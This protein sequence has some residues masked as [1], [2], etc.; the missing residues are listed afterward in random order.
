MWTP[1]RILLLLGGFAAFFTAYQ[2]YSAFLGGIDGLTPL[3]EDYWPV[4]DGSQAPMP[5]APLVNLADRKLQQAF[6]EACEELRR[7]TKLEVRN[8]GLVL[9]VDEFTPV[10]GKVR[11]KPFSAAIFGKLHPGEVMPEINT[12][13][14]DVALLQFDRPISNITEMSTRKLMGAELDGDITI[15]NNRRTPQRDD[16]LVM[17]TKGPMF[18]QEDRHWIGTFSEVEFTDYQSKPE[19]ATITGK[20]M[21]LFLT[22]EKGQPSSPGAAHRGKVEGI[23]GVERIVL[24]STVR[25]DLFVDARSG[26]LAPSKSAPSSGGG[27]PPKGGAPRAEAVRHRRVSPRKR[28]SLSG[29]WGRSPTTWQ[30]TTR[31]LMSL[32][33]PVT[34]PKPWR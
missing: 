11:L 30:R 21:D 2:V 7:N 27:A 29:P 13:N 3:P 1:K 33:I 23:S 14:A 28:K 10:D 34:T 6:G 19:K 17:R 15:T 4:A 12:V 25:M 9:A 5:M 31:V 24:L 32:F 22:T 26:F 18:Y 20:G 16:D 8:R